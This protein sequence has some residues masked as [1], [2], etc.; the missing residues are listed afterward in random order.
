[1]S[2]VLGIDLGTSSLKG[3]LMNRKGELICQAS[4]DY[5]LLHPHVGYSEQE[6]LEWVQACEII[7]EE[8]G[9]KVPDFRE[10][11]VGL[12]VSGQMHGLVTLDEQNE[13]VRPAILWND[14]RTSCQCQGLMDEYG[15]Q[16]LLLTKNKALEGFT[17]P[18]ILWMQEKE[19]ELWDKVC[20]VMLPKDYLLWWL[21]GE[22]VTDYS[23]A[24]G[25]L[26]L[27]SEKR[28][29]S[30]PLMERYQ[31][32]STIL[33]KLLDSAEVVASIREEV[34]E[35]FGFKKS[36]QVIA[37]GADNACAAIGAGII[38]DSM[39]MVSIGTSG[40][41]LAYEN[42]AHNRYEG[43]L[44]LF[45]HAIKNSYYSMGVTLAAG[46]S[47]N[48][49]KQVFAPDKTFEELLTGVEDISIGSDGLL[50]TPYIV[51]ERTPYA[52]SEVRG[53]FTGIDTTHTIKH[54]T[55]SV[56]EGI[57]FSL[58]QSQELMEQVAGKSFKK[59]VSVGGGSKSSPWLQMQADI[60]NTEVVCLSVE[61]GPGQGAAI[62][63]A[64][65]VGW[66]DTI[67]QAVNA[68]VSY[69]EPIQPIAEQVDQYNVI[70]ARYSSVYPALK[71][72]G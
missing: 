13:V 54:F 42:T 37:G 49:F 72:I 63:A 58:K 35:Q 29:W 28:E 3:L 60:F 71:Q 48:W 26:L 8:I 31:I 40:V 39:G 67:E 41:F 36:V 61:Q 51:G 32:S 2:Y 23:D 44:H 4:A 17:L 70:Y 57:T 21:T 64:V 27:D 34:R 33:P 19:P 7:F 55:R 38:D 65:G 9:H 24:A 14:T 62:L 68:F 15:S 45:N 20:H 12:S 10:E 69:K 43:K 25:T 46:H 5:P 1:M 18:K 22:Y 59:I 11:L 56:L 30:V 47:L 6:P 66:F 16:L 53:S 52:D 50:F